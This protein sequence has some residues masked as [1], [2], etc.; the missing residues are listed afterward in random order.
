MRRL[1]ILAAVVVACAG[2][3][4]AQTTNASVTGRITDSSKSIIAK[5]DVT[6]I[7]M[8]TNIPYKGETNE[9]GSYYITGL[10]V[11][12][13]RMEVE[14]VG[15]KTIIK[16]GIVFHVQDALEVNFEMSVGS[17]S[18][19]ITVEAGA[20]TVQL[21]SSSISAVVT[22]TTVLELPL[23]GRSW[24]DLASLQPGV[25]AI[26]NQVSFTAGAD[27]G[28]R[29]FGS[30]SS[31]SGARPQQA[32]YRLDGVSMNDYSNGAPGSVLGGNLGVD[33]IQE[34]SVLTSNYAAE[35]GK[36]SGGVVNAV[37]RSGTNQFHGDAYEFLRNSA[38]DAR[39][40]FDLGQIPPFKRNQFGVSAGGPIRKDRTFIF[41]DFEG[42]RQNTGISE[43]DT[44]PSSA[45]RN[46][47]LSTGTVTVDPSVQKYLTFW[48]LPNAGLLP[49]SN[50]DIGRFVFAGQQI[51]SENFVTARLD[52]KFSDKD[53]LFATYMYD[54]TP[55]SAPDSLDD[56]SDGDLTARQLYAVEETHVFSTNVV[57][58]LRFGFN[59][60]VANDNRSVTAINPAGQ[61]TSL[62]AAPGQYAT[63]VSV[64]GLTPFSGGLNSVTSEI[65]HWNSFQAYDDISISR[66]SH[67]LRF[68]VAIERMQ[69][70]M[71][72][73]VNPGGVFNF[74]SLEAF[75]TNQPSKFTSALPTALSPR[76]Y[77]Q[78]I[79]AGYA[80]DDWHLRPRVTI[81]LGLRYE[82]ATDP[83]EVQGKLSNLLNIT[84][85]TP[86]VGS[87]FVSNPTLRN[88]DPRVGFA[89]DPFGDGKTAVRG[90]F[91]MFDV[92]P[93][94][95]QYHVSQ[96]TSFPF[97][98]QGSISGNSLPPGSFFTGALPLLGPTSLRSAYIESRPDR[99]YVM[100]WNF[101]VQRQILPNFTAM[102]GY[103]GSRGVHLPFTVDDADIVMPTLTSQGYLWPNPVG[104]GTKIN[105]NWGRMAGLFYDSNSF[106]DA[107]E[108]QL[109]KTMSHGLLIQGS[110]T[111]SKSID[112]SSSSV[113]GDAF[114]N[115]INSLDYFDLKLTRAVSD[116][117][118]PR[119]LVIGGTWTIP[120][121]QSLPG[122][123][124]WI[125]NGWQLGGIFKASDGIPFT[126]T[127][128]SDGDPLGLKSASTWDFP[129]RLGGAGCQSLINPG[130]PND[131]I[132]TQCFSIPTAPS[133]AFYGANCDPKFAFPTCINL[134]GN[135][136]R[137][138]L[139]GPGLSNLDFSLFKNNPV[140]KISETFNAQFRAEF[141]NVLNRA[142]FALP[143][144]PTNTDIFL[145]NTTPNAAAGLLTSTVTTARE[146]QLALKVIW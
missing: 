49:N 33:A 93:M 90:G 22:S 7:N 110:Y 115:S 114:G 107:L 98:Q 37:T 2:G 133:T 42:L 50:G 104:S 85:A 130:N 46:G 68:G 16:P 73:D 134:R 54:R 69:L 29:G 6:L 51:V 26:E 60:V 126:P 19:S 95:Y 113:A 9:T 112:T 31:I 28:I 106:Y 72:A 65:Y 57:N 5:V 32:N 52:Q 10:P 34:F 43:I 116:F 131:Y 100:Q 144:K 103:V 63:N 40:F 45:A 71:L 23:N 111:W 132:K 82:M 89:W 137:N 56:M 101:N 77:R 128:G 36:T 94:P 124:G 1:A 62:A 74:P 105:P 102:V 27:R 75:L 81:N 76:G 15:F 38:L 24:T 123:A 120:T 17:I 48:P 92:L 117:N 8:A 129:T 14:K 86:H 122:P 20:P 136:G 88:F 18:Q 61:D 108:I 41:G 58:S 91:G 142:N 125:A 139:S 140:K 79:V 99:S 87:L 96:S 30:Q 25:N 47:Q 119:T 13:Y 118:V 83:T 138:I 55:F 4:R 78:T 146:I 97:F 121:V 145:A 53:R 64:G 143:T 127:F 67:S 21:E 44:V 70:N 135:A 109:T 80:Q 39:N 59:R 66:G 141:F 3:V 35:Y 11:G 12:T 84:D